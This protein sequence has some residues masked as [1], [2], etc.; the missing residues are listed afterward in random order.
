MIHSKIQDGT[1]TKLLARVTPDN[2]LLVTGG[3]G[4]PPYGKAQK[5]IPLRQ[6]LTQN[7]TPTGTFSMLVNGSSTYVD[8]Y[9]SSSIGN[10]RYIS[11]IQFIV[12]DA[13]ATLNKFGAI[14][15]LTNG[16]QLFYSSIVTGIQYFHAS[17]KSNFDF[18]RLA[19]GNPTVSGGSSTDVWKAG[20]VIGASDAYLPTMDMSFLMPPFG[21]QLLAGSDQRLTFRV[22]D[23]CRGI[24][25]F[26]CIV[27]G[28]E[29]LPD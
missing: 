9:I 25:G 24:D 23:D 29:R 21:L 19:L 15:A 4:V 20:N 14:T 1:G 7:G 18:I 5:V 27:Y 17:L 13:D 10:D 6:Y 26:D 12:S 3:T 28:F 8:Y 11:A 16:C 22:R 2:A